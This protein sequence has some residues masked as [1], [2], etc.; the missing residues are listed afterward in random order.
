MAQTSTD[1]SLP[2]TQTFLPQHCG[3]QY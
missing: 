3:L 2:P 1:K